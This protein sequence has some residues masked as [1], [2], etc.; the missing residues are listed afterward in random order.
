MKPLYRS[1]ATLIFFVTLL[2]AFVAPAFADTVIVKR[3]DTLIKIAERELGNRKRYAEICEINRKVLGYDCNS[4]AVGMMLTLPDRGAAGEKAST[5]AKAVSTSTTK[6]SNNVATSESSDGPLF[7]NRTTLRGDFVASFDKAGGQS[8]GVPEGFQ[9]RQDDSFVELSGHVPNSTSAGAP[10]I[11]LKIP[12]TIEK[13][14][15][16]KLIVVEALV[17]SANGGRFAMAYSTAEVGNSGWIFLQAGTKFTKVSFTYRGKPMKNGGG[18][19]VGI[20]PDPDNIG[21][22]LHVEEIAVSALGKYK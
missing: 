8:L 1:S 19:Y 18:D 13:R 14:V 11:W 2:V 10:G 4:I 5:P 21:Q 20:L 3:G 9:L 16:G 15:S 6:P 12:E 17:R 22:V 7:T